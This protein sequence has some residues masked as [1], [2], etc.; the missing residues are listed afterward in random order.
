[1]K[2]DSSRK[3]EG[4]SKKSKI[5]SRPFP[6]S[7]QEAE[8]RVQDNDN[9]DL[10]LSPNRDYK[11]IP[12]SETLKLSSGK[13]NLCYES[14]IGKKL[15][16]SVQESK[17]LDPSGAK[18]GS[19]STSKILKPE[20]DTESDF[21]I[22]RTVFNDYKESAKLPVKVRQNQR[23]GLKR[24]SRYTNSIATDQLDEILLEKDKPKAQPTK[25]I[26]KIAESLDAW[27]TTKRIKNTRNTKNARNTGNLDD[28]TQCQFHKTIEPS[29]KTIMEEP[30]DDQNRLTEK[31]N[32]MENEIVKL[33][34]LCQQQNASLSTIIRD[35]HQRSKSIDF[36]TDGY[37]S[38]QKRKPVKRFCS[39]GKECTT[40]PKWPNNRK[41]Y[42]FRN[43]TPESIGIDNS[44]S[45][46]A[47][48]FRIKKLG[49]M[50]NAHEYHSQEKVSLFIRFLDTRPLFQKLAEICQS[51][52]TKEKEE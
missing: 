25:I 32:R 52:K 47:L 2:I 37:Y 38:Q 39:Q 42:L 10:I 45:H 26:K 7:L 3:T 6:V 49:L 22:K 4:S 35:N 15:K 23:D 12:D 43:K 24:V 31:V 51:E 29:R 13:K 19:A 5:S 11:F 36:N 48:K 18:N 21:K 1:M 20:T 30:R 50:K 40:N 16:M 28:P 9:S 46:N 44:Q 8:Q 34:E 14:P 27:Q 41:E 17:K 33:R